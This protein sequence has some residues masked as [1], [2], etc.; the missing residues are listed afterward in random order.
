MTLMRALQDPALPLKEESG[1][2]CKK[3]A[4]TIP[5]QVARDRQQVA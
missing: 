3:S 1:E 2:L 5:F 4:F